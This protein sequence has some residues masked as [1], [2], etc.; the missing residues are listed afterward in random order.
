VSSLV[1][2]EPEIKVREERARF[3]G[4]HAS[5]LCGRSSIRAKRRWGLAR[6]GG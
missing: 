5:R 2:A 6:G 3:R 4:A 1:P